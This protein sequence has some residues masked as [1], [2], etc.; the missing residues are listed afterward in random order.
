MHKNHWGD[1][2]M[3]GLNQRRASELYEANSKKHFKM[4]KAGKQWLVAGITTFGGL[5]GIGMIGA[6]PVKASVS[7]TGAAKEVTQDDVAATK[8]TGTIPATSQADSQVS[9]ASE[10]TSVSNSDSISQSNSLVTSDSQQTS[11]STSL[12]TSLS[13]S[14]SVLAVQSQSESASAATST[15]VSQSTSQASSESTSASQSG[16][17]SSADLTTQQQ[18]AKPTARVAAMAAVAETTSV[19]AD[20]PLSTPGVYTTNASDYQSGKTA[21]MNDLDSITSLISV[22]GLDAMTK[23]FGTSTITTNVQKLTD[24]LNLYASNSSLQAT[25]NYGQPLWKDSNWTLAKAGKTSTLIDTTTTTALD[26]NGLYQVTT[27]TNG[28]FGIVTSDV[29]HSQKDYNQG[30]ADYIRDFARGLNDWLAQIEAKAQDPAT[31][32]NLINQQTYDATQLTAGDVWSTG[33]VLGTAGSQWLASILSAPTYSSKVLGYTGASDNIANDS[34]TKTV[35]AV[36]FYIKLIAPTLINGIG[37]QALGDIRSIGGAIND[38]DYVPETLSEAVA[39]NGNITN[40]VNAV[41]LQPLLKTDF[42]QSVYKA[43]K[44]NALTAIEDNWST[45]FNKAIQGILETGYVYGTDDDTYGG[46]PIASSPYASIKGYSDT[47]PGNIAATSGDYLSDKSQAAGYAWAQKIIGNV[48]SMA[49]RD[50]LGGTQKTNVTQIVN[51]LLANNLITSDE[52]AEVLT[53]ATHVYNSSNALT[54]YTRNSVGAQQV[55]LDMYNAEYNAITAALADYK[56]NPGLGYTAYMKDIT[57]KQA[58]YTYTNS[59]DSHATKATYTVSDYAGIR[60]ALGLTNAAYK[61]MILADNLVHDQMS[62]DLTTTTNPLTT[63]QINSV[64]TGGT[65]NDNVGLFVKNNGTAGNGTTAADGA[66]NVAYLTTV[67]QDVYQQVYAEELAVA[68]QAFNDGKALAKKHYDES[69]NGLIPNVE[70]AG[71]Y[72]GHNYQADASSEVADAVLGNNTH[73]RGRAFTD[74]YKVN[75]ATITLNTSAVAKDATAFTTTTMA[76]ANNTTVNTLVNQKATVTAPTPTA[77]WSV[78]STNPVV[79]ANAATTNA[80]A[81]TYAQVADFNYANSLGTQNGTYN[82]ENASE[83]LNDINFVPSWNTG[84]TGTTVK[85]D[86][87]WLTVD[88]DD[89]K[90]GKYTYHL[91]AAGAQNLIDQLKSNQSSTF[92]NTNAVPT[93]AMLMTMTGTLNIAQTTDENLLPKINAH[94]ATTL[95]NDYLVSPS[96]YVDSVTDAK[97]NPLA[98]AG[99][100]VISTLNVTWSKV[101]DYP[102]VITLTDPT[103]NQVVSKTVYVHVIDQETSE[104][105]S[106]S[107][108]TSESQSTSTI[109]SLSES[110]SDSESTSTS[111]SDSEST[112]TLLSDSESV[113]TSLSDSESASTSLSD[114]ESVST[115]LSDSESVSTSMS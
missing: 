108:S 95:I 70:D 16:S 109:D 88:Q 32:N 10:S 65:A 77:G 25:D 75:L 58:N 18:T 62:G 19:A 110:T 6:A 35:T 5:F 113:S 45:G 63:A 68:S 26:A 33:N 47:N 4:Y 69:S 24:L 90:V 39:L 84:V 67:A 74:G 114:S 27:K 22:N 42:L 79:I 31:A 28:L 93:V 76:A 107:T 46:T 72:N 3:R 83:Q 103:S 66:A 89:I 14:A 64:T 7:T 102:V 87:S 97:G 91:T 8:D 17:T 13:E 81:F 50:S 15:S 94:D 21:A 40:L 60:R 29:T 99:N 11:E 80:V 1:F 34:V 73:Y 86:K 101:G 59:A 56:T 54:N 49:A 51:Q 82:G 9:T 20:N 37:H 85:I 2:Y 44:D 104:S 100:T 61:A 43:I 115:S 92:W 112:S 78:T 52:A 105:M 12:Q 53:G 38:T 55:I 71:S 111:V 98:I 48:M 57:D 30:Y 106:E 41:G 96:D 23:L 36:N